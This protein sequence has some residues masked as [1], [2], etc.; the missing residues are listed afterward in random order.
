[1]GRL[2]IVI[3]ISL[4][5]LAAG[6]GGDEESIPDDEIVQA[7]KLEKSSGSGGYTIAGDPFC[8]VSDELLNDPSEVEEATEGKSGLELVITDKEETVGVQ[9][10]PPFDNECESDAKRAL[11]K[12]RE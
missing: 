5:G 3:V 7:L 1:V 2:A 10:L 11:D 8:E 4:C 6:C 9:G 12:L